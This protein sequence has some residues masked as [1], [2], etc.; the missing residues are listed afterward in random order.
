MTTEEFYS[1]FQFDAS[2]PESLLGRGGFGSVFKAY[3]VA[4]HRTVAVK[5]CEVGA[6]IKF[7][8]AREVQI[9]NEIDYNPNIVRYENVYRISDRSGMY[10]FVIMKYY[11]DGNLDDVM[12]KY[13]LTNHEKRHILKGILHGLS[14][15]HKIP[16]VHRD[17]KTANILM[18]KDNKGK[19]T[20]LIADFGQSRLIDKDKSF[21]LNNSQIALT[22]SYSA[23][24]QFLENSNLRPNADLW[25]LGVIVYRMFLGK[26]PFRTEGNTGGFESSTK[27]MHLILKSE[28][29]DELNH[30]SQ[31]YQ[32]I[33]RECLVKSPEKRVKD[34]EVLLEMLKI[35]ESKPTI[36]PKNEE[37]ILIKKKEPENPPI[38]K[39]KPIIDDDNKI[40][41]EIESVVSK[42]K[43]FL[44]PLRIALVIVFGLLAYYF[45]TKSSAEP[46]KYES[47]IDSVV[48]E[49]SK[50]IVPIVK[51]G[52][53]PIEPIAPPK[54]VEKIVKP[55]EIAKPSP[56]KI[57]TN[58]PILANGT[59]K[60]L[61]NMDAKIYIDGV[62]NGE[63][64]A[65]DYGTFRLSATE[66]DKQFRVYIIKLV[67]SGEIIEK[68][69]TVYS[70]QTI[71]K[72]FDFDLN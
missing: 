34:A 9:A 11:P 65:N 29:P 64:R 67:S 53:N 44:S 66:G 51:K 13:T 19:W 71:S 6:Y 25:A 16:I 69:I 10:D 48:I 28:L 59:V 2:D 22:P 5:R 21:I 58:T 38:H 60:I 7:D 63:I 4:R 55:K 1:R 46:V 43:S 17:F 30:V 23:P 14:H 50:E 20:P 24:E 12:N 36:I 40:S 32:K 27:V 45:K 41:S 37:T 18:E 33:I 31:P 54:I 56:K 8:L 52:M 57:F 26:L 68:P 47:V 72:R 15:L 49:S 39:S 61:T 35:P 70:G 3:D 62:P 42:S